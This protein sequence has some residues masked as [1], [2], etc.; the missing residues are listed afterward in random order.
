MPVPFELGMVAIPWS[1]ALGLE[2]LSSGDGLAALRMAWR[3]DLCDQHG[4]AASGGVATLIDHGCGVAVMSKLLK[5]VLIAT[6]NLKIDHIRAA[7]PELPI[8]VWAHCYR[9]SASRA[10]VRAE[11]WD[12]DPSDVFATA[13]G[14]FSLSQP[15]AA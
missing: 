15:D 5:P 10:F 1:T 6:L 11:V 3:Y 12:Q 9:V 2:L 14:V 13:Q 8:T 7:G 4:G